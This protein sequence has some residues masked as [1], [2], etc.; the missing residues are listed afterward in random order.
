MAK[1]KGPLTEADLLT[2]NKLLQA[3]IETEQ[4]CK[5]CEACDLDVSPERQKNGEQQDIA[6]KIKAKFFPSAR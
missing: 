3:T 2:L 5:D 4:F 6:R 1:Q